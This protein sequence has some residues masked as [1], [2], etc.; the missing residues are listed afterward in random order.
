LYTY[1][2]FEYLLGNLNYLGEEMFIRCWLGRCELAPRHDLD[3]VNAFDKMHVG[4][5]I[6]MEWGIGGLKHMWKVLMKKFDSIKGKY[7]H[8]FL[9]IIIIINFVHRNCMDFTYEVMSDQI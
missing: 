2:Y 4:Y 5:K 3:V 9:V 7:N 1:E 6:R 8:F